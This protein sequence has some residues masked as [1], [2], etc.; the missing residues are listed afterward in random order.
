MSGA[1]GSRK[2][3]GR[4]SE[5]R[6]GLSSLDSQTSFDFLQWKKSQ[7]TYAIFFECAVR[8][9]C[10]Q[11]VFQSLP[12]QPVIYRVVPLIPPRMVLRFIRLA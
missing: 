12:G 10:L 9:P 1:L 7:N 5:K 4:T 11:V 2:S 3:I 6:S 8:K